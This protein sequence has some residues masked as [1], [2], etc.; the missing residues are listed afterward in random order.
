MRVESPSEAALVLMLSGVEAQEARTPFVV[1]SVATAVASVLSI[2]PVVMFRPRST[3]RSGGI[4]P[5]VRFVEWESCGMCGGAPKLMV[6]SFASL[7]SKPKSE[8]P[9]W[10]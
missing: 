4:M 8:N 2:A 10:N 6:P 9:Y 7:Y 1:D 5:D 3:C